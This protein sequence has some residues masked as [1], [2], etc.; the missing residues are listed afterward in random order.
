MTGSLKSEKTYLPHLTGFRAIAAYLVLITHSIQAVFR[1]IAPRLYT[2]CF[3]NLGMSLFFV[4]SGFVITYTYYDRFSLTNAT[5]EGTNYFS[6]WWKTT[7]NFAAA[8]FARLYPLYIF[9]LIIEAC[10]HTDIIRHSKFKIWAS[11]LTLTQSWWHRELILFTGA[12]SISTEC[13]FYVCFAI[14]MLIETRSKSRNFIRNASLSSMAGILVALSILFTERVNLT[15]ILSAWVGDPHGVWSWWFGYVSPYVRIGEF[16]AGV[17]AARM[18]MTTRNTA[19]ADSDR[20]SANWLCVAS[21]LGI[22][23]FTGY[24]FYFGITSDTDNTWVTPDNLIL[25]L[26]L[27]FGCAPFLAY[28]F[29]ACSRYPNQLTRLFSI[30]FVVAGGEISYSLYLLQFGVIH[31]LVPTP[32]P[33]IQAI[34]VSG[35]FLCML[36][37]VLCIVITTIVS[38]I[39]YRIIEVPSRIYLRKLLSSSRNSNWFK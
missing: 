7:R 15:P 36:K 22:I 20:R 2:I 16:I 24:N 27:N 25:F 30:P 26:S 35:Y 1:V 32:P 28:I 29:Y 5:S 37:V 8:R 39:T 21:G 11:Y 14:W 12:W 34:G 9:C 10:L 17:C 31:Y 6:H 38:I 23:L 3:A 4:L 33:A 13:F 18:Y 19:Y